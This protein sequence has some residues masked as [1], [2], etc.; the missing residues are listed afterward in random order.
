M[1]LETAMVSQSPSPLGDFINWL[2][3]SGAT[4]H[5]TPYYSDLIN[6]TRLEPPLNIKV[7]DGT[8]LKATFQGETVLNFISDEGVEVDLRLLRV[9]QVPGLQT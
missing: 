2:L 5:F 9:L 1:A 3:D 8:H 7:A 4:S 6:P